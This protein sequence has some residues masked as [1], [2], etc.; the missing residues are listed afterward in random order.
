M[1]PPACGSD[2]SVPRPTRH[3]HL[4]RYDIKMVADDSASGIAI[5]ELD[6]GANALE[7]RVLQKDLGVL[8][9]VLDVNASEPNSYQLGYAS[10]NFVET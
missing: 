3:K 1:L 6:V 4:I 8:A 7:Q 9:Q 10:E 5:P 2:D